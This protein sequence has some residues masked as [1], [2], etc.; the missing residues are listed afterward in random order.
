MRDFPI[1]LR[2]IT[3][4]GFTR[5]SPGPSGQLLRAPGMVYSL[6]RYT[7]HTYTRAMVSREWV[8]HAKLGL[9]KVPLTERRF[10]KINGSVR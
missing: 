2:N 1:D 10:S 7:V 9:G 5:N 8:T 3:Q 4:L 6:L